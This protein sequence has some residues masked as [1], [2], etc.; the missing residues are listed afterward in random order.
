[1]G[2]TPV[3]D[4]TLT[5]PSASSSARTT[6]ELT[7]TDNQVDESDETITISSTSGLVAGAVT[8]T[9][10]DDDLPSQSIALSVSPTSLG[11]GDGAT[12]FTLT[13]TLSSGLEALTDL[14]LPIAV[15]GS[16]NTGMVGFTAVPDFNL[17]IAAEGTQGSATFELHPDGQP[18]RRI[19][20]DHHRQQHAPR[21]YGD[22]R[23]HGPG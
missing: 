14:S 17:S 8:V 21:R 12:T 13:G 6:F 9:L 4:F 20:R 10:T 7:P 5:V 1:M 15:S 3:S 11:E 16:G 18:G 23:D 2:F 22:G 19:G